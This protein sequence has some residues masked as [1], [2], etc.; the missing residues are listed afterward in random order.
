MFFY[1]FFCLCF[2]VLIFF[3]LSLNH[4]GTVN[5]IHFYTNQTSLYFSYPSPNNNQIVTQKDIFL[6]VALGGEFTTP[7]SYFTSQLFNFALTCLIVSNDSSFLPTGVLKSP[8]PFTD[9]TPHH[10]EGSVNIEV[11]K[12][13]CETNF[14][15]YMSAGG[16]NGPVYAI[17][18]FNGANPEE[19]VFIFIFSDWIVIIFLIF[20]PLG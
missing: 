18:T 6:F 20:F 12:E 14:S 1:F 2:V 10:F 19:A 8:G 11:T 15:K 3:V 17:T 16:P 5:A 7:D 9:G 13:S 4:T